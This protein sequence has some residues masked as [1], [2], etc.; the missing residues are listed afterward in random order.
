MVIHFNQSVGSLDY[1]VIG[2]DA[3]GCQNSDTVN[4]TVYAH[5]NIN[6]GM[7]QSV[8]LGDQV[9]LTASGGITYNWNNGV[10][11]GLAFNPP[12]GVNVYTVTG[13]DVNGCQ[14]TDNVSVTVN[15]L[16]LIDGGVDVQSCNGSQ[17]TLNATGTVNHV[18]N[19]G[20]TDGI[21]F[22]PPLGNSQYI[23]T[24]TDANGCVNS[25]SVDV[26][27]YALPPVNAGVDQDVCDGGTVTLNGANAVSYV[28]DNGVVDGAPFVQSVG[29]NDYIVTGTDA[30]GCQNNDTVSVTVNILPTVDAGLDQTACLGDNVSLNGSGANSYSWNNGV[31][32]GLNFV[33]PVGINTYTVTGT[34]INGCQN[35]DDVI[36][37]IN[38]LPI[39][40]GGAD[41]ETCIGDL[42]TLTAFGGTAH[43]WNG[44][45]VDGV[46]FVPPLGNTEYIVSGTDANGC[47]NADTVDVLV[48]P[49]PAVN[50]GLD[51]SVCPSTIVSL[52]GSG[53]VTYTWD[54][55]ISDGTGF[56]QTV[57]SLDYILTGT[58]ANGC[59]NND[60]VTIN[61]F[62]APTILAGPDVVVCNGDQ[63]VLTASGAVSYVWDNGVQNGVG[64]IPPL[65]LSQYIVTGTDANGC[66]NTDTVEILVNPLPSIDAGADQ[67]VCEGTPI[68]LNG[69]SSAPYVWSNGV[70]DNIAFIQPIG[71]VFY[72]A[73]STNINGCVNSDTVTVMVDP[74]PILDAGPDL[75]ICLGDTV[76]LNGAGA[77][78]YSWNNGV[79]DGMEFIPAFGAGEYIVTGT[80]AGGCQGMDTLNININLNP[81]VD[82]GLDQEFCV[83]GSL[84]LNGSG[85]V[86]YI[87]N[88]GNINGVNFTPSAGTYQNILTGL[89]ANG[90]KDMDT[91]VLIVNDLPNVNAGSDISECINNQIVLN[92]SGATTYS[93]DQGVIDGVDFSQAVGTLTYTVS[94]T[95][96]NGCTASDNVNVTVH[97]L[98][99][100]ST[101]QD[102]TLCQGELYTAFGFGGVSYIWDNGIDNGVPFLPTP[103]LNEYI[104]TGTD[105]NGCVNMDTID[106][107]VNATPAL[108]SSNDL[109]VCENDSVVLTGSG[110]LTFTWSNGVIDGQSF[111]PPVGVTEYVSIGTDL[112]NC[113][114][115]DTVQVTVN[116]LPI[117]SAGSN[118]KICEGA[119]VLLIGS[120]ADVYVWNNGV[121]DNQPFLQNI[122][123]QDYIVV[124]T[125]LNGCIDSD[126]INVQVDANPTVVAGIDQEGCDGDSFVF[127]AS[128]ATSFTWDNGVVDNTPFVQ[129]PGI[130][131]YT[132]TGT[133]NN[134]CTA[135]D[136]LIGTI[137]NIPVVDAG[138]DVDVCE[139]DWVNLTAQGLPS[140]YWNNNIQNG[141]P[142]QQSVGAQLY[143][144]SDTNSF[145]CLGSDTVLVN[146]NALPIVTSSDE[147]V[148]LNEQVV[149]FG[150]GAVSYVWDNNVIDGQPFFPN[151]TGDYVVIGTD[152]N[153][154][155]NYDTVTVTVNPLP[156][157]SFVILDADLN[158]V[159]STTGFINNSTGGQVYAWNFGDGTVDSTW[160][161]IH[162]FPTNQSGDYVITLTVES[163]FGCLDSE[164]QYITVEQDYTLFVPNAFTPNG[165]RTNDMLIPISEGLDSRDYE[166]MVFDRWGEVVFSTK[167]LNDGWDG[168]YAGKDV[169]DGTYMWKIVA[170]VTDSSK[171]QVFT[172][173]VNLIK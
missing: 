65:G 93:W 30:N 124:G 111:L 141:V 21:A 18:W 76:T 89:D 11:D 147:V 61:V 64:F 17:I 155:I 58:D 84:S 81:T 82:A 151:A 159:N 7:D 105:A 131:V 145:G 117:V 158:T 31:V 71:S 6:T 4:V 1:V 166:F 113:T 152:G 169:Q 36:V 79:I 163:Q 123:Q 74:Y 143:I 135:T 132:V 62:T 12:L 148:C 146:V 162:S 95:D 50:A 168:T 22:T 91:M 14:N 57:P 45:V 34:D 38:A 32:D 26:L 136:Q 106:I 54:S 28:W 59:Q 115:N 49:L 80:T 87:W 48:N 88:N 108:F 161:P 43:I 60:T 96:L 156:D 77:I 63:V 125:D 83:G 116:A 99:N 52:S 68:V 157:A 13:A 110:P 173:H 103:G 104:V 37:I 97:S 160:Q 47:V 121:I 72:V 39:I 75:T 101:S 122:G 66:S 53:A 126:T 8:C 24:G 172:G 112:N 35:T 170:S 98:P 114:V 92:A 40:D 33:P 138:L 142:F 70:I 51:M 55:G 150:Q 94:G 90:C 102:T 73:T 140:L 167:K 130:V 41:Q 154:C 10:S 129:S 25:D 9:T 29:T 20:I 44:G 149:L 133:D 85:A 3:S 2:T 86:N 16:P 67:I 69:F 109:I 46:A 42:I 164:T 27:I 137:H 139:N 5:P 171:R 100:I 19:N 23:V 153:G 78:N 107:M 134:G 128:G 56:V 127:N 165:D 144:V 120:G 119:D 15:A 118:I